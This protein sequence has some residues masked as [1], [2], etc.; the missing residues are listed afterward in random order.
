MK[1]KVLVLAV[2]VVMSA[3][4]ILTFYAGGFVLAQEPPTTKHAPWKDLGVGPTWNANTWRMKVDGGWLYLVTRKDGASTAITF[5][6][7]SKTD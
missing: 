6:P 5:V 1:K 2:L 3:L 7:D 4:P